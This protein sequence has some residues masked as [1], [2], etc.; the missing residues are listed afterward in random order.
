MPPVNVLIFE[1]YPFDS[2]GG[3]QRTLSYILQFTDRKNIHL[4]LLAP[5]ETNF[6]NKVRKQGI[7]C[8]VVKPSDRLIRYGG[9]CLRDSLIGKTRMVFD[10]IA[11]NLTLLKVIKDKKV[12]VIYCNG[13]RAVLLIA[14]AS[15]LSRRPILW[16]IK[17]ELQNKILDKVGFV[18][19]DKILFFCD[20]NKNDKYH[21][22]VK[23]YEKKIDILKIGIDL[24][25]IIEIEN[26]DKTH[27]RKE[28]SVN[29]NK[30]NIVYLGQLYPPKGVH[31]LLEA[32]GLIIIEFPNVMLY[33]VGDHVIEEYRSY[34]EE[35][36]NII[37]KNKLEDNVTFT[38]WRSDALDIVSLMDILVHPSLAEGFGRA[39]LE[40]M[41]L[42]KPVIASRVGGLRE[43]IKNGENGFLVE[44]E[45]Y[46]AI[47]EK[48]TILLKDKNLREKFGQAAK[49]I[50]FSEYMIQDKIKRLEDIWREMAFKNKTLG[51]AAPEDLNTLRHG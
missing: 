3:N 20:A 18:L 7:E 4:S 44:P 45:D 50:V 6:L 38:G 37:K 21:T 11:Y 12:D 28:L 13:I 16:Y 26:R 15:K 9:Q 46:M 10:L 47:A 24:A 32:L 30:I 14:I 43:I 39:V 40:A 42:G 41:A 2:E 5:F 31:Y 49:D 23:R 33:I 35:L 34:K 51:C 8:I 29:N 27:L 36:Y 1:P 25:T 17:G 22:V 19:A 48:L